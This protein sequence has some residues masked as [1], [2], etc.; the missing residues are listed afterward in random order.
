MVR[1]IDAA[2]VVVENFRPGVKFLLGIDHASLAWGQPGQ[3][4]QREGGLTGP[5]RWRATV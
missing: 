3:D 4:R 1:L 2:D 5:R